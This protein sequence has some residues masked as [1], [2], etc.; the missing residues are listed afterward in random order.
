MKTYKIHPSL[1]PD[2]QAAVNAA[3]EDTFIKTGKCENIFPPEMEADEDG[4][5]YLRVKDWIA[6]LPDMWQFLEE[7]TEITTT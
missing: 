7:L 1:Y 6:N 4:Y 5:V 3:F 2:F